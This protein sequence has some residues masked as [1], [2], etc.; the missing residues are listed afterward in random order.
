MIRYILKEKD[1][2]LHGITTS[3]NPEP[4]FTESSRWAYE[5]LDE[6]AAEEVKNKHEELK[7]FNIVEI[8]K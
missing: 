5:F 8:Q 4:V 7:K 6:E 2:Y 3:D 1:K